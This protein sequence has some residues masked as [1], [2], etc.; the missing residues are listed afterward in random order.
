MRIWAEHIKIR[1]DKSCNI[2]GDFLA[3]KQRETFTTVAWNLQQ[4]KI[5][6]SLFP[7]LYA[8]TYIYIVILY[9]NLEQGCIIRMKQI[10]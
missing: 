6:H 3:Y 2:I 7:F 1:H 10:K 9:F 4:V 5:I 8:F